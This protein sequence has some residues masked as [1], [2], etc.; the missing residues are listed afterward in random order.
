MAGSDERTNSCESMALW[1]YFSS[2][3]LKQCFGNRHSSDK[4][5]T[6]LDLW[7][8]IQDLE[9]AGWSTT[10]FQ[11][12]PL[13][14]VD[15]FGVLHVSSAQWAPVDRRSTT[16][17]QTQVAARQE[18]HVGVM[19]QAHHALI[20]YRAHDRVPGLLPS[21]VVIDNKRARQFDVVGDTAMGIT[22]IGPRGRRWPR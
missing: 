20:L 8:D 12:L 2:A 16:F 10:L 6:P 13:W 22:G 18:D 11:P 9:E 5:P 15:A 4:Q 19:C 3:S 17:A 1:M 14:S 7:A 21:H